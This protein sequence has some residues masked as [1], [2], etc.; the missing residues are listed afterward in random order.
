MTEKKK[1]LFFKKAEN[2]SPA[3]AL[4]EIEEGA[5]GIVNLSN[6]AYNST[7][8]VKKIRT[9]LLFNHFMFTSLPVM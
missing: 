5:P 1:R 7:V 4:G 8:K 2:P 9:V 6:I 3:Y